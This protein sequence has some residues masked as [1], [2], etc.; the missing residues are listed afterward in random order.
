MFL[1]LEYTLEFV[2]L[3]GWAH[4]NAAA[5]S[6]KSIK[7]LAGLPVNTDKKNLPEVAYAPVV[8]HPGPA[9]MDDLLQYVD[10]APD[11]ETE[12]FVSAIYADRR[13]A[14]AK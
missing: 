7:L 4:F 14:S 11:Q 3:G 8:V 6:R 13:E 5:R 10:P 1:F 12:A 2:L 9:S